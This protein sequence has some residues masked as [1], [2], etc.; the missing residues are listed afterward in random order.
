[1]TDKKFAEAIDP[2]T[3]LLVTGQINYRRKLMQENK[4]GSMS[5]EEIMEYVKEFIRTFLAGIMTL[6]L[7]AQRQQENTIN[8]VL[9]SMK[10]PVQ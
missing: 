2:I 8:G 10:G 3:S 7:A 4:D 5:D 6:Q 1:M 9:A